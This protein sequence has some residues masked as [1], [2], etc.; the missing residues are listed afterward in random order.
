[1]KKSAL[2]VF[3]IFLLLLL[4][5]CRDRPPPNRVFAPDDVSGK[6]IGALHGSP[7]IVLAE[8]L[9]T[10]FEFLTS[11]ELIDNLRAGTID[12]AIMENSTATEFISETSGFRTLDVPLLEYDMRFAVARENTQLLRIVDSALV[13]LE[14]NGTIKGLLDQYL[15]GRRYTYTPPDNVDPHPGALSLAISPENPPYSYKGADGE[16]LGLDIDITRAVCD[17][18][19]VGLEILEFDSRELVTA[20]WYGWADLAL[21]WLPIEGGETVD[22]SEAYASSTQVVIV[23]R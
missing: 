5:S 12:C 17:Y 15:A 7:S 10:A 13:A 9:G 18:L 21:G 1:M 3:T 8:E 11:E 23:R 16:Y 14:E 22:V 4:S 19:G 2:L 20:V 6:V